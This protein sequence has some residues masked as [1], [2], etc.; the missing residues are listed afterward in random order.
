M[1]RLEAMETFVAAIDEGSLAAAAKRMGRSAAAA[2]RAVALLEALEGETLLLRSTR[3][4]RLTAAGERKL[5]LWR[6]VL[7]R[8]EEGR[9]ERGDPRVVSGSLVLTAPEMFGRL[10]VMPVL[11]TF[12]EQNRRV[13]ARALLLNRM[14]DMAR[15]GVDIAVRLAHLESSSLTTV[16]LGEVRQVVCASAA[17][18]EA[19][20]EPR[21]PAD[22]ADHTCILSSAESDRELWAFKR[23]VK[24]NRARSVQ[25][26]ARLA[27]NSAGASLDAALRGRGVTRQLSYQVDD[28]IAAGRLNVVLSQFEPEPIPVYLVFRANPPKRSPLRHFIDH[29]TPL[30]R[31]ELKRIATSLSTHAEGDQ[32]AG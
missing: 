23:D 16:K 32:A 21:T 7:G 5:D 26:H 10:K 14:V 4:L 3:G 27:V 18:L 15:E 19:A 2:T 8:L 1:D 13:Q 29:A 31:Q 22:L 28:D 20:G 9:A 12:L 6:E 11:E 25:V 24:G 30:L 17:Y